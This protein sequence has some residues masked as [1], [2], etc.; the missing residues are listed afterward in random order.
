MS[1]LKL[2]MREI[3][4]RM[5]TFVLGLLSVTVAVCCLVGAVTLLRGHDLRTEIIVT[6]REA[7]TREEMARLEDDYRV[8]MK[9]MGY[10]VLVLH[11]DQDFDELQRLGHPTHYMPD[12]YAQRLADE[13]VESL[14]HLLPVLQERTLWPEYDREV[15]LMGVRG[16]VPIVHRGKSDREPITDPVPP[17][18]LNIGYEVARELGLSPG[19]TVTMRGLAFTVSR[20]Y[21]RRGTHD[22]QTVWVN[23]AHAQKWLNR[24]GQING[25]LALECF[26]DVDALGKIQLDVSRILPDTRVFEFTSLVIARAQ[27]RQRA[28]EAH[29]KAIDA[30]IRHRE[31][32]REERSAFAGVL[33]PVTTA[34][35]GAWV[36]FVL[37]GNVRERRQ[38]IGI[39]RAI[40]VG[41]GRIRLVFVLKALVIG[42]GGGLVGIPAGLA[43]GVWL[44]EAPLTGGLR[45]LADV[46]ILAAALAGAPLLA[47]VA[48]IIPAVL[49]ARQDPAV[50]L[51]ED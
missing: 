11:K 39:L 47:I 31:R 1:V 12:N 3:S 36:F 13:K 38:E 6:E 34:G 30:E 24:P 2:T 51:R 7:E 49:A 40:G 33:V 27:A 16:Q 5:L 20:V 19:D 50:I 23:L 44:S 15:L 43:A 46:R 26:C 21:Q 28:A 29:K 48:S 32:L 9:E 14:N 25:I 45:E 10:N 8:I 4:H 17:D 41:A 42:L 37:L 35:A 18:E 22:D